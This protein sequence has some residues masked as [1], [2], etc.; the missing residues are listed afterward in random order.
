[1]K[2]Y[3][4]GEE[5]EKGQLIASGTNIAGAQLVF[6]KE[7]NI[8]KLFDTSQKQLKTTGPAWYCPDCKYVIAELEEKQ[9]FFD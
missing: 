8:K 4:C 3:K 2:C 5:M 1:M 6:R 9:S 7:E